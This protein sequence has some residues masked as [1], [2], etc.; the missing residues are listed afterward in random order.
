MYVVESLANLFELFG[1]IYHWIQN[2]FSLWI[3]FQIS[4]CIKI[5]CFIIFC[6]ETNTCY[7]F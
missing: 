4:F 5:P 7:W 6:Q 3:V 2:P 1:L